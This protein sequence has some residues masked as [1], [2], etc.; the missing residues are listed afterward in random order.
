MVA[1]EGE[2]RCVHACAHPLHKCSFMLLPARPLF[3]QLSSQWAMVWYRTLDQ[4]LGTPD[5]ENIVCD[6]FLILMSK[7]GAERFILTLNSMH[8]YVSLFIWQGI[9]KL[10]FCFGSTQL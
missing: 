10:Y 5:V 8:I 3:G 4:G 9:H 7:W 2:S 6:G 1:G